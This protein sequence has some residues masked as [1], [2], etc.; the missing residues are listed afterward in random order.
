MTEEQLFKEWLE[1]VDGLR[2][3]ISAFFKE[4][5]FEL[6]PG[7]FRVILEKAIRPYHYFKQDKL[8]G[9]AVSG[10]QQPARPPTPKNLKVS[11]S[12]YS[13]VKDWEGRKQLKD[14]GFKWDSEAKSWK[15]EVP[16]DEAATW[17]KW[18]KDKDLKIEVVD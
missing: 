1:E 11:I 16:A 7:V 5:G 3:Q 10:F 4:N 6:H 17:E 9:E 14:A 15:G 13:L 2:G 8:Q 12:G 18:A